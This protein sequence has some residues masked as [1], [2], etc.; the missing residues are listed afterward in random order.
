MEYLGE[1][2]REKDFLFFFLAAS[3]GR[4]LVG[5]QEQ[6]PGLTPGKWIWIQEVLPQGKI[7]QCYN[8]QGMLGSCSNGKQII[9]KK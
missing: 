1:S 7:S 8:S 9:N 3:A 4:A 5:K 2:L 6:P